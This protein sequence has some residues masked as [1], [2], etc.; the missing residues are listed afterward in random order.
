MNAVINIILQ[1]TARGFLLGEKLLVSQWR[2]LV[3][4]RLVS[5][6][7]TQIFNCDIVARDCG[8]LHGM[9]GSQWG[10]QNVICMSRC[11]P[12]LDPSSCAVS[13][14]RNNVLLSHRNRSRRWERADTGAGGWGRGCA[15]TQRCSGQAHQL[16]FAQECN[17]H[18][19]KMKI[20]KWC[21]R[22]MNS[23]MTGE[24]KQ[25]EINNCAFVKQRK[26]NSEPTNQ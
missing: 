3:V 25:S 17:F 21:C 18:K 7:Q 2:L 15:V 22:L 9:W 8:R 4:C 10:D 23:L 19:V 20:G 11:W 13:V 1:S 14:T 16:R 26:Q 6:G 24:K 12:V 5:L